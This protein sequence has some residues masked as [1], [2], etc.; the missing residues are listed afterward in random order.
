MQP[1]KT[2]KSFVFKLEI[3][4][5]PETRSIILLKFLLLKSSEKDSKISKECYCN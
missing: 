5:F 4:Y 3:F 1:L 2:Q